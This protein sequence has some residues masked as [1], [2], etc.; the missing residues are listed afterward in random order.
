[1]PFTPFH[2]GIAVLA[3]GIKR[4]LN[5]HALLL[6]SMIIDLETLLVIMLN[7]TEF[8]PMHGYLHTFIGAVVLAFVLA[9][10][11]EKF[12]KKESF[13]IIFISSFIGTLSHVIL[14]SFLYEDMMPFFPFENNPFFIGAGAVLPIY[15]FCVLSMVV[16]LVLLLLRSENPFKISKTAK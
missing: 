1:M 11:I 16:G 13:K 12:W 15:S 5:F 4:N 6:G 7:A 3:Y 9:K 14:D 10:A 8:Y 2:T